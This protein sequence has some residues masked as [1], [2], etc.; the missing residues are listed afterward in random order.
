MGIFNCVIK[1]VW[2]AVFL[3]DT[4]VGKFLRYHSKYEKNQRLLKEEETLRKYREAKYDVIGTGVKQVGMAIEMERQ[5]RE[6]ES[7]R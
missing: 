5:A 2:E 6:L 1:S 7:G 3:G 4:R